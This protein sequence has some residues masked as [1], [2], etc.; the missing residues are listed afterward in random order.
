[1]PARTDG[2][3]ERF[4]E[5]A[6][7]SLTAGVSRVSIRLRL[8]A[9]VA[10]LPLHPD[11]SKKRRSQDRASPTS[12]QQ[13]IMCNGGGGGQSIRGSARRASPEHWRRQLVSPTLVEGLP[14][15]VPELVVENNGRPGGHTD[16]PLLSLYTR[17]SPGAG[18][19]IYVRLGAGLAFAALLG[20]EPIVDQTKCPRSSGSQKVFFFLLKKRGPRQKSGEQTDYV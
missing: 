17:L 12:T 4:H 6:I 13:A 2:P 18:V 15:Q 14:D 20:R 3:R 5:R 7:P 10:R 11:T 1:M 8:T 19:S 9:R 16:T